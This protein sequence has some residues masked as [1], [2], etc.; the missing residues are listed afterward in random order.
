MIYTLF[1]VIFPEP[2]HH[3]EMTESNTV[4]LFKKIKKIN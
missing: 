2:N 1:L 4:E 3:P